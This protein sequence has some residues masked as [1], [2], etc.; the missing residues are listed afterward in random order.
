MTAQHR[1]ASACVRADVARLEALWIDDVMTLTSRGRRTA[2]HR[3][4][5]S[6]SPGSAS[7]DDDHPAAVR[8]GVDRFGLR[9]E[10]R[11][12]LDDFAADTGAYSSDT[13]F[14][15]SMVPNDCPAF[16]FVPT[17]G[18]STYTTSPSCCCA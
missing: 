4:A 6:A 18:S 14:T 16:S 12:H 7:F 17:S 2:T 13:A 11:V 15:D 5:P 10:R 9:L 3:A 1:R 8:I